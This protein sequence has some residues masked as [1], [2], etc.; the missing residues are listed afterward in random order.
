MVAE[1]FLLLLFVATSVAVTT[2]PGR[3]WEGLWP[4]LAGALAVLARLV[5]PAT[6]LTGLQSSLD[7]LAFFAGLLLLAAC[8][9]REGGMALGLDLLE[10]RSAGSGRRL[11]LAVVLATVAVTVV[12][13]NDAAALLLAPA[14]LS[15]LKARGL[16]LAP[17][18]VA[19]ALVANAASLVLPVSNPVN[20]LILDRARIPLATYLAELTPAALAG[21]GL[22]ALGVMLLSRRLPDRQL[23]APAAGPRARVGGLQQALWVLLL[24]LALTD[25]VFVRLQLPIGVPTLVAGI[26][27]YA[28]VNWRSRAQG[29]LRQLN[30][31][32]LA[33]VLGFSVLASGLAHSTALA[34]A[35][36]VTVGGRTGA[37]AP[38]LVGVVTAGLSGLVNNLPAS[39]LVTSSLTAAHQLG[40]LALAAIAGADL[41]PNLA[42][43][44][45]LSTILLLAAVRRAGEA[46]PWGR[47]WKMGLLIGPL[48]L[49]PSLLIVSALR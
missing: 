25:A 15:R 6:A 1:V 2:R 13:S 33:L 23:L 16:P 34:A 27:A 29:M 9:H 43:F 12:L 20:L 5:P 49:I 14:V 45:S 47:L 24:A 22:T 38:L 19:M 40:H 28:L 18:A 39:L 41:G 26:V 4:I 46:P 42:P 11:L 21:L 7:V 8:L 44:G 35:A 3:I 17:F 32:L 30:W 31:G 36:R 10:R 37:G 48:A